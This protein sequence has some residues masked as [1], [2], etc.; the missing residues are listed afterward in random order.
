[1]LTTAI[2]Q[3]YDFNASQHCVAGIGILKAATKSRHVQALR[4]FLCLICPVM[5]DRAGRAERLAGAASVCQSSFGRSPD[6]H[7]AEWLKTACGEI[8]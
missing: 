6:W 2:K 5:G 8:S 4:L 1:M 3:D 7:L